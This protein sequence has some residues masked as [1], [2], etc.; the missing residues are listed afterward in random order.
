MSDAAPVTSPP[1]RFAGLLRACVS[2]ALLALLATR[3]DWPQV[4]ESL[5]EVRLELC[6]AAWLLYLASQAASAVRWSRLARPLGFDQTF[7]Q[8]LGLYFV[9]S[10]F[11]LCLPGSIGGD[12]VKALRLG[13]DTPTRILAGGTVLADRLAG[14]TALLVLAASGMIALRWR[15]A[16]P[17][18]FAVGA[19]CSAAAL[20]IIL[21]MT[22]VGARWQRTRRAT[23]LGRA[24]PW[25]KLAVYATRPDLLAQAFAWSLVV[26]GLNVATVFVLARALEIDV[27]LLALLVAVPLV[28]L[29]AT[30]PITLQGIGVREG[31][32]A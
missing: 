22:R 1:R 10:F 2:G 6:G 8:F 31:G 7:A 21:V 5:G 30:V 32:L 24:K 28:A 20:G 12:V 18:V 4:A 11:G 3:V 23:D 19:T 25:S 27:P 9:G 15:I 13:R 26:Q 14:L 17:A 16:G 29:A